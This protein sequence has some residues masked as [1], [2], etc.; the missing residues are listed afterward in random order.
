MRF[1][2]TWFG[3]DLQEDC[4]RDSTFIGNLCAMVIMAAA[5]NSFPATCAQADEAYGTPIVVLTNS[6][7]LFVDDFLIHGQQDLQRT[8]HSPKKDQDGD[9]P[10]IALTDEFSSDSAT[11]EANGSIV[12]DPKLQRY[13]MFALGFSA[14]RQGWDRVR[15]YRYTSADGLNWEKHSD[16]QGQWIYPRDRAFFYDQNSKTHATNI[17]LFSCYFDGNDPVYPYKGWQ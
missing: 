7:Q 2:K 13:V 4:R 6:P 8:L 17:D 5:W 14:V 11:L 9:E 12:Y 3:Q 1:E 10:V 16:G 15:L